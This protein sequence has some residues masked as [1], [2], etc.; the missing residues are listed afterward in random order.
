[1]AQDLNDRSRDV[2]RRLVEAYMETGQPVGSRTLARKLSVPLS[3]A[4]IRNVM[5]DLEDAGLLF[6]PHTSAGRLPT[7]LGLRLFVDGLLELGALTDS[8]RASIDGKCQ[9]AGRTLDELL[10]EASETLS[11][12]SRCASLVLA[13][14]SDLPFRQVEF[15]SL[16]PGRALV[17][18]VMESGIVEN[19]VID[20]P[21]GMTQ[22]HLVEATNFLNARLAGRT[23]ADAIG[24]IRRDLDSQR[25][26]LDS[27]TAKIVEAGIATWSGQDR[28]GAL[29]VRGEAN[30]LDDIT[31][32][33]DLDRIRALY[34]TLESRAGLV[35]L[36]ES[37]REAE[38]V[39]I[40][41]GAESKLFGNTECSLVVAPFRGNGTRFIGAIGVVGPTRL[42][43]AR[44]I[45]M[46]SHTAEVIGRLL[47]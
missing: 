10:S 44:I 7:Q 31:V 19:R 42:N 18:M 12:L 47:S 35:T 4:T 11:G 36:L 25:A 14:K 20:V 29:I 5:A 3:P 24:E 2:L 17:V 34:E 8:E 15:V 23:L 41:I 37:A 38:G 40:F 27:L 28:S 9:A 13:P 45:P 30:L 22:S 32:V 39:K 33:E 16:G 26:Q 46:V 6:A 43:Y 1:M 21:A